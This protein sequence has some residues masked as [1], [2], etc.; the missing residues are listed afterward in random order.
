MSAE[1]FYPVS[2][3]DSAY[4]DGTKAMNEQRWQDAI[5]AFDKVIGGKSKKADAA[6][7]WKAYSLRKLGNMQATQA[8]CDQLRAQFKGSAW[9][10]DCAALTV[11]TTMVRP[12][13]GGPIDPIIVGPVDDPKGKGRELRHIEVRPMRPER[14]DSG[15]DPDEDIKILAM[16]SLLHQDPAK[17]IPLLRE[18]LAGNQSMSVKKHALFVLSQSKAPEAEAVLHDAAL[19]KMGVEIQ[20]EAIQSMGIF[21]G[22]KDNGTLVEVYN[23][24]SDMKIKRSVISALFI[25]QD[26]PRLVELARGEK[27]LDLKRRIVSQLALMKDQTATDYMMELLK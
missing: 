6:L 18:M 13:S 10:R 9:N 7:Y 8:S 26:A 2:A 23:G 22:K 20:A 1:A 14:S 15:R 25:S 16:N 24:T 12:G 4:S 3:E 17:A 5:A 21:R 27:D 19:G 11:D